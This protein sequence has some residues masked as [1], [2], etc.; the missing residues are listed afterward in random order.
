MNDVIATWCPQLNQL[1]DQQEPTLNKVTFS[2]RP[3]ELLVV[4]G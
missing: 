1:N 2:V 3:G 4:V